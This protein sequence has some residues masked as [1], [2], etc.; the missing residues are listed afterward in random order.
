MLVVAMDEY[1]KKVLYHLCLKALQGINK[2]ATLRQPLDPSYERV[3]VLSPST[4]Q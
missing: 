1:R 3:F 4:I 2:A